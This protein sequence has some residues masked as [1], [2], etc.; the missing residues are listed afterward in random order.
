MFDLAG[1]SSFF[2]FCFAPSAPLNSGNHAA[3]GSFDR[4]RCSCSKK[5]LLYTDSL[6]SP[7][8]RAQ[9][10]ARTDGELCYKDY[11]DLDA[12][13]R[14]V[15]SSAMINEILLVGRENLNESNQSTW[16]LLLVNSQN[17]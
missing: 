5:E 11:I 8:L 4:H 10:I 17:I 14:R 3:I 2:L 9:S 1:S 6:F 15:P 7:A 12:H 16:V 13:Y